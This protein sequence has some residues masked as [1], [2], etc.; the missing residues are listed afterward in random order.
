MLKSSYEVIGE[1]YADDLSA[2]LLLPPL[3]N[4]EVEY[5]V[6]I[7]VGQQWANTPALNRPY[8]T[9][10]PL[11]LFQHAR[12]EPFLD[13]AHDAP[14]GYAVLDKLHQPSVIES[15]I[16][17]PDVGVEHPVHLSRSDPYR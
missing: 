16:E 9:L 11:T 4:P 2:R 1:A 17:L 5:V 12:L 3:L 8:F 13:Q 6:K 14:V 10:H 15:V 7:D